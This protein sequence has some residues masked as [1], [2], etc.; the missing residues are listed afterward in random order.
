MLIVT[1]NINQMVPYHPKARKA[2]L[3]YEDNHVDGDCIL[4]NPQLLF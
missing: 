2:E 1:C 3:F 4:Y